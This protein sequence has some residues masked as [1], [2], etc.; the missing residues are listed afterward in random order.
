MDVYFEDIWAV[1][2]V[3]SVQKAVDFTF[4]P[5]SLMIHEIWEI[6][7][8][9]QLRNHKS[10]FCYVWAN[11]MFSLY[12]SMKVH[13]TITEICLNHYVLSLKI[14]FSDQLSNQVQ[15]FRHHNVAR[16]WEI[17]RNK[18]EKK[19]SLSSYYAVVVFYSPFS[20]P[21][22]LKCFKGPHFRAIGTFIWNR[23]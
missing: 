10:N 23:P 7:I 3:L 8:I 6:L 19:T 16:L 15:F 17:Q 11:F 21:F 13:H 4:R 18:Y 14:I 22:E 20:F 5:S 1:G 2:Q 12:F 9:H